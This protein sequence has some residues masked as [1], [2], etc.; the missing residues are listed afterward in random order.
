MRKS[1]CLVAAAL[2]L[3]GRVVAPAQRMPVDEADASWTAWRHEDCKPSGPVAVLFEREGGAGNLCILRFSLRPLV[4]MESVEWSLRLPDGAALLA[5]IASGGA[6][7]AKGAVTEGWA[8][9]LLPAGPY[10]EIHLETKAALTVLDARGERVRE[11]VRERETLSLGVPPRAKH[12]MSV[13]GREPGQAPGRPIEVELVPSRS[14]GG[15]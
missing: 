12:V 10:F 9:V 7:T 2:L 3:H 4:D 13:P 6:T 5:G 11:L 14:V 8:T 15:R 1:L